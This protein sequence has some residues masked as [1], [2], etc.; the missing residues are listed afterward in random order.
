MGG[1]Q[2]NLCVTDLINFSEYKSGDK[3][4][5]LLGDLH[6]KN[7]EHKGIPD[8]SVDSTE[9]VE[10][11]KKN[12][13]KTFIYLEMSTSKKPSDDV[14]QS[15]WGMTKYMEK[16]KNSFI[17]DGND[18]IQ[19]IGVD[20]RQGNP[21]IIKYFSRTL[22]DIL[23]T[24]ILSDTDYKMRPGCS[25]PDVVRL[26]KLLTTGGYSLKQNIRMYLKMMT[27]GDWMFRVGDSSTNAVEN[28]SNNWGIEF[29]TDVHKEVKKYFVQNSDSFI[30]FDDYYIK[31]LMGTMPAHMDSILDK[32]TSNVIERI[33][34]TV[35]IETVLRYL[36][37]LNDHFLEGV[38]QFPRTNAN[39][40]YNE[41]K[42][43]Y[44]KA[45]ELNGDILLL[46]NS[47]VVD[48]FTLTTLLKNME[49]TPNSQHIIWL[50]GLHIKNLTDYLDIMQIEKK[51]YL[52]ADGDINSTENSR[53]VCGT[54]PDDHEL[55][56]LTSDSAWTTVKG[57]GEVALFLINT[58]FHMVMIIILLIIMYV[59]FIK[60][61]YYKYND[62]IYTKP[63]Y[64]VK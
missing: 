22:S 8:N 14:R 48:M 61:N 37:I 16:Y 28:K 3:T 32:M 51:F 58:N 18:L 29:V 38:S 1:Q 31:G 26:S 15:D 59:I 36:K 34:K 12:G 55:L 60:L 2:S 25:F 27:S 40:Y 46:L 45:I 56:S 41:F 19:H 5:Y 35:S 62:T 53:F 39:A 30:Y 11:L 24:H 43:V 50:G 47:A 17:Q 9:L 4:I 64:L 13:K 54:L 52:E 21:I 63:K 23:H 49:E 44:D 42:E 10:S 6:D 33:E 20:I 57:K 7:N